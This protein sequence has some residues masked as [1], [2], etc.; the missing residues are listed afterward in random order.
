MNSK[1]KGEIHSVGFL[2]YLVLLNI[3]PMHS[4]PIVRKQH[5]TDFNHCFHMHYSSIGHE[6]VPNACRRLFTFSLFLKQVHIFFHHKG[7]LLSSYE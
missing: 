5:W 7:L 1:K 2:L 3:L 6:H 4:F